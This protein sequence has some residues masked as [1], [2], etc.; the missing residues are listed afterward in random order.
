M[1]QEKGRETHQ[2]VGRCT[3]FLI[4]TPDSGNH[5]NNWQMGSHG[6]K[7]FNQVKKCPIAIWQRILGICTKPYKKSNNQSIKGLMRRMKSLQKM[8][9]NGQSEKRTE[10]AISPSS[11]RQSLRKQEQI[12]HWWGK[13][14]YILLVGRQPHPVTMQISVEILQKLR[15]YLTPR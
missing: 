7:K 3:G 14:P 5:G 2:D 9:T 15:I 12:L 13:K 1:L 4:E 6:T 8:S 11:E 10:D